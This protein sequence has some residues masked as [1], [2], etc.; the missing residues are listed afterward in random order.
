VPAKNRRVDGAGHW[1]VPAIFMLVHV[2]ITMYANGLLRQVFIQ[3]MLAELSSRPAL[4]IAVLY[5]LNHKDI[6]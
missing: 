3:P 6:A 1:R 2:W 5:I 4:L